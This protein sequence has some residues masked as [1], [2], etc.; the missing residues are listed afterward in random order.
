MAAS[1]L[2]SSVQASLV[3]NEA[4][5]LVSRLAGTF[6]AVGRAF[7]G[8]GDPFLQLGGTETAARHRSLELRVLD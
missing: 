3:T 6:A 8:F 4:Q 5:E 1:A 7:L 2:G